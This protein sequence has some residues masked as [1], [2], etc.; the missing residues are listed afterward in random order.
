M[1]QAARE[2]TEVFPHLN[3]Y[4]PR[5]QTWDAGVGDVLKDEGKRAAL[6]D[7]ILRFFTAYP[8][9]PGL[10]LDIESLNDDAEPGYLTF[11]QELYAAMHARNLRLYVNVAASTPDDELKLIASNSDGIV[12]M[13][14][15]EHEANSDPGPVASQTWFVGNLQRVLKIVPKE[16]IICAVGSYG[17]DWTL[18][19]PDPKDGQA[20]EA[21][22]AGYGRS[23]GLG[24]V[25]GGFGRGRRS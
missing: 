18:S 22:G 4:N 25:A 5:T 23:F 1:I 15:D 6:R 21:E 12:L 3:N 11:I 7:Q 24:S 17:Y 13:N 2:D 16:K 10:S 8:V 14:Y 9:Y 19:I 20:P